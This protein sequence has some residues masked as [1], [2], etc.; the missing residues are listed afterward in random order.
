MDGSGGEASTLKCLD[1]KTGALKWTSPK[2]ETG[3]LAA[4][5]DGKL[6]WLTGKGELVVVQANPEKY[7]EIARAQVTSGKIWA[8]PVLAN[9]RLYVR[10]WKGDLVCVDLRAKG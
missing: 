5:A 7:E 9:G 2:A 4:A 6:L 1:L 10:N 3:V 8:A